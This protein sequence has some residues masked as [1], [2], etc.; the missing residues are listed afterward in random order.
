MPMFDEATIK[1][2]SRILEGL[3][4]PVKIILFKGNNEKSKETETFVTEFADF[5]SKISLII[6]DLELDKAKAKA[7]E[8]NVPTS[9]GIFVTTEDESLKGVAFFGTPG[10]YEV[11]SFLTALLEVSG[12]IEALSV[13][14]K[15]IIDAI[16][17][18]IYL[19]AYIS[20]TCPLCPQ[21][22]MNIHRLAIENHNIKSYMVEGFAFKEHSEKF[23]IAAFPTIIIGQNE[24]RLVG[25]NTKDLNQLV[26]LLA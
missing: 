25:K 17:T 8:W 24:N 11:N 18:P 3:I 26:Q 1:Q 4:N 6:Y 5:S 10:G 14:H 2:L 13:E 15:K 20:L 16:T 23:E 21:A 12:K 19:Q 7:E 22:V 9:P